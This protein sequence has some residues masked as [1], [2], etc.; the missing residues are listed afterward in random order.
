MYFGTEK[1]AMRTYGPEV[2][3]KNREFWVGANTL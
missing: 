2:I 3:E 1:A